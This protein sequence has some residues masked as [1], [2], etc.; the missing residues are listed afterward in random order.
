MAARHGIQPA[1]AARTARSGAE[2]TALRAQ[3]FPLFVEKL[4]G[5]RTF[6]DARGVGLQDAQTSV[7]ARGGRP[8]PVQAPPL[9]VLLL[10][11]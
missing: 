3:E 7:M 2:L 9:V 11:T 8:V 4:G 1:A 6:A 5:E 10:V